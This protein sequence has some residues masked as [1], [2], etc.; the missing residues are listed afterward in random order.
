MNTV[1]LKFFS[2]LS[3]IPCTACMDASP[4]F[5][6]EYFPVIAATLIGFAGL[7]AALLVPI[8]RFLNR[9]QEVAEDWTPEAVEKRLR[10]LRTEDVDGEAVDNEEARASAPSSD[11]PSDTAAGQGA[12]GQ[13]AAETS[14]SPS[15]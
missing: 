7:A 10:E 6:P 13:G 5:D 14:A 8:W 3:E 12:A 2:N 11:A 9:E 1:V 4:L 15:H